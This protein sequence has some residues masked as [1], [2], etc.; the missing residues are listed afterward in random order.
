MQE[1]RWLEARIKIQQLPNRYLRFPRVPSPTRDGIGHGFI[2]AQQPTFRRGQRSQIPK[3]LRPA[4]NLVRH[5]RLLFQE[6]PTILNCEKRNAAMPRGIVRR[7]SYR[8]WLERSNCASCFPQEK[9][10]DDAET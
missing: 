8:G 2:E 6:H 7:H 3:G 10:Q 1:K 4:V 5:L 9:Q